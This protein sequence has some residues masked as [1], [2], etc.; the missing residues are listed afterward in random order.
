MS[1]ETIYKTLLDAGLTA[2]GAC[3]LMGNMQAE[4][5]LRANNAQ[6]G[7]TGYSDEEYTLRFNES[8]EAYYSDGVGYGLCQWTHPA[9]KRNLRQ[10]ARNWGVSVDAEDMQVEFAIHELRTEYAGLFQ[11]LCSTCNVTEAARRVCI[12]FER[13]AINNI[14][15]RSDF[16]KWFYRSLANGGASAESVTK[17]AESAAAPA[18]DELKDKLTNET[19]MHLQA[20]LITYGYNLS[21]SKCSS[22][23]DGLIGKKTVAAL[24]DFAKRLEAIAW[25]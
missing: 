10:F 15:D 20:I 21:T 24:K 4:S 2:A 8:P 16:A 9:R 13:P 18:K 25:A 23:V 12:E 14:D 5:A 17:P 1:K 3:G 6:D 19:V 22:G 7:M 11:F